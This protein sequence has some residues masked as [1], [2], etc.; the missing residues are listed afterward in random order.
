MNKFT[1]KYLYDTGEGKVFREVYI[2]YENDSVGCTTVDKEL[3][4][5]VKD[6]DALLFVSENDGGIRTAGAPDKCFY[7][8]SKIGNYHKPNCVTINRNVTYSILFNEKVGP[9]K[10]SQIVGTF[11]RNDP[12]YWDVGMCEFHKNESSWCSMNAIDDDTIWLD[13]EAANVAQ[14][15]IEELDE[16]G[17]C[18]CGVLSFKFEEAENWP[19]G[20]KRYKFLSITEV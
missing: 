20:E 16:K 13:T 1:M 2:G 9:H 17:C 14:K 6:I 5:L 11:M 3:D 7:C 10:E 15:E 12:I 19:K 8:A 4:D 18:F